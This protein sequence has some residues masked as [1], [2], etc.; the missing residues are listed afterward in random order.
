MQSPNPYEHLPEIAEPTPVV[1]Q[2]AP[3]APPAPI[4][5]MLAG[6]IASIA[7]GSVV[8]GVATFSSGGVEFAPAGLFG[9]IVASLIVGSISFG[10]AGAISRTVGTDLASLL[11]SALAG[12][13]AGWTVATFLGLPLSGASLAAV[14]CGTVVLVSVKRYLDKEKLSNRRSG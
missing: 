14:F 4:E 6:F 13:A 10:I 5:P 8:G 7:S 1:E 11:T 3:L 2:M 12:A 9:G